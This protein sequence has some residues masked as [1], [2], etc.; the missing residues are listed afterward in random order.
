MSNK[1][2][3]Q[4]TSTTQPTDFIVNLA[5]VIKRLTWAGFK[6]LLDALYAA[7]GHDHDADY[8]P[9][10]HAHS[11]TDITSG[12][13][14]VARLPVLYSGVQVVS[15]GGIADLDGGQ[16]TTITQG[17]VVTT[18]D[19]RRWVYSGS[20]SKTSEAS[21]IEM[22]DV[23]PTWDVI[24]GKPST[25]T[26][27]AHASAHASGGA[28]AI[29]LDDLAAPD[30]N[31]DLDATTGAH[32]LM[33]KAD[34]S[35]LNGIEASADV[36]DAVNVGAA[37]HGAAEKV[38]P[39]NADKVALID[40]ESSN[41]LKWLSWTNIKATLKTYFDTLYAATSH[42]H[43]LSAL[44]QSGA[45]TGQVP[46]WSGTEWVPATSSGIGGKVRQLVHTTKT[47][48][49]SGTNTTFAD[50]LTASITPTSATSKILILASGAGS[51]TA[52]YLVGLALARGGAVVL[53]GD[54]SG[55]QT[56][57][58]SGFSG[59][60]QG[61]NTTSWHLSAV[62]SPGSTSALTYSLQMLVE[63]GGSWYLNRTAADV[64]NAGY[65]ATATTLILL[66]I[67]P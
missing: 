10:S 63:S 25:F 52:G 58:Q 53:Q 55:V 5:G 20:G 67:E 6:A 11:A 16:Q 40:T 12:T 27:S 44:T 1:L 41:G 47:N 28:D 22:G 23:S 3:E 36:T 33:S 30:D 24:A 19:G 37:I 15:T 39:V 26:P 43:A 51:A 4:T 38:T 9:I 34:K 48:K 66:E 50:V 65:A 31:T 18:T 61:Y 62:D 45:T 35:K 60:V 8:A 32:G 17:A 21:Y 7:I 49:A 54:V 42:T 14:D 64:N 29:K 13:L 59:P 56:R 2:T 46:Q 57:A